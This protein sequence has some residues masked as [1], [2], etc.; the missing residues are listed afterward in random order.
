MLSPITFHR[1]AVYLVHMISRYTHQNLTWIDLESP[2]REEILSLSDDLDLHPLVASEL[3]EPSERAKVD[4]YSNSI[5]LIL[6]FPIRN[7]N[8]GHIDEIEVDFVLMSNTLLTTH[9][10]LI[11][12]LHEF[13]KIFEVGSYLDKGATGNHAGFLFYAAIRELYKHTLFIVESVGKD[14]RDVEKHIFA[15]EE[16]SMVARISK[17]NRALIDIKQSLRY[18]RET[19]KSFSMACKRLYGDDFGYYVNAIEGEHE[20]IEQAAD[21]HR[22][23]LRDLRETNDSLLSAKT[24]ATIRR[25]T[26]LNVI[27]FPLG[28]IT[29]IFSMNSVY[30]R[31]DHPLMLGLVFLGMGI[32]GMA[33]ILYFRAKKW[34]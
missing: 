14:I 19:L 5:Y 24:T 3:L 34:L 12:P 2:T 18:H 29:W 23:T 32:V 22:Q 30:L 28:F 6:H 26:A 9:Y 11:D 7:K 13:G 21:E 4:V 25:L 27:L 16:E 33:S 1:R 17:I 8:T 31:L 20:R 10:E 15:S